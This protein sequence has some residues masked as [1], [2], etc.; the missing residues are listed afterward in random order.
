MLI[1]DNEFYGDVYLNV[2]LEDRLIN[3]DTSASGTG[4]TFLF[5]LL[6]AYMRVN[7]LEFGYFNYQS[8]TIDIINSIKSNNYDYIIL[9]NADLYMSDDL[10]DLLQSSNM[11]VIMSLKFPFNFKLKG[12]VTYNVCYN[13]NILKCERF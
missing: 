5:S 11:V 10:V 12:L 4:K 8:R 7:S 6:S 2:K 1:I 9:D 3:I 13:S